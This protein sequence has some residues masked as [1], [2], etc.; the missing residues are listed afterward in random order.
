MH[1]YAITGT[2]TLD[3]DSQTA[4][5]K[6]VHD[7]VSGLGETGT[8]RSYSQTYRIHTQS[9]VKYTPR[10]YLNDKKSSTVTHQHGALEIGLYKLL[11]GTIDPQLGNF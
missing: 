4:A 11:K 10:T 3:P 1:H 5:P 8:N 6:A 9:E 2:R 7:G